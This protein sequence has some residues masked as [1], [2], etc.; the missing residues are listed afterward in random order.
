MKQ[1][2]IGY[3]LTYIIE[4]DDFNP[5]DLTGASATFIMG[6][7]NKL[8]INSP[9][10]I[11]DPVNGVVEYEFTS[12]NALVSGNFLGE[13]RVTFQDGDEIIYPRNG[14][15]TVNI[16]Q[17]ID[18]NMPN[19]ML[20]AI[21]ER[22][23]EFSEKLDS[24]LMQAGNLTMTSMNE[25]AWEAEE[26]QLT[27][28]IPS[29]DYDPSTK[30]FQVYVDNIPVDPKLINRNTDG[31]FTLDIDP[32][33]IEQGMGVIA[34]WTQP[35]GAYSQ[36]Y[37]YAQN[38]AEWEATEGQLV[39]TMPEGVTYDPDGKSLEV[40]IGG[41]VIAASDV[42]KDSDSQ[43]TL[44][45]D[46][47][48][49]PGGVKVLARWVEPYAPVVSGHKKV[50]EKGG[51][52][53]IDIAKLKNYEELVASPLADI[54]Y[55]ITGLVENTDITSQLNAVLSTRKGKIKIPKGTYLITS[56]VVVYSDTTLIGDGINRTILKIKDF[57]SAG[58]VATHGVLITEN[59]GNNIAIENLTVDGNRLNQSWEIVGS[60][61]Y[62][63]TVRSN[64]TV[65][66]NVECKNV[67]DNGC[68]VPVNAK[69]V[70]FDSVFSHGNGKKG[71]HS[72]DVE[73]IQIINGFYYDN[74]TDCGIGMHQGMKKAIITNNHCYNNGNYGIMLGDSVGTPSYE[75]IISDNI[76]YGNATTDIF[77]SGK[78][79]TENSLQKNTIVSNNICRDKGIILT[80]A[81][82]VSIINN[83]LINATILI[84]T[85]FN[86]D[87]KQNSII[88]NPSLAKNTAIK[89]EG[90][91]LTSTILTLGNHITIE[92]NTID[93]TG[94]TVSYAIEGSGHDG[95]K[96]IDNKV[97]GS[98]T[99][100]QVRLWDKYA[101]SFIKH[102]GS[103]RV[104]ADYY[105]DGF[106]NYTLDTVCTT[107]LRPKKTRK[108][109]R[110]FDST[111]G[112]PIWCKTSSVLDASGNVT[113]AAVWVDATGA[114]V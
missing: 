27:Y 94:L 109:E 95:V 99:S 89:V 37:H 93:C 55:L 107:A 59:M 30:W 48:D 110:A 63:I 24:I 106:N 75:V 84:Q 77:I 26:G 5:V 102:T 46:S 96:I 44:L 34:R 43:F 4:D 76:C 104:E 100:N 22:Q 41:I 69:N 2:D 33:I 81:K 51:Y 108:G 85:S 12:Q 14:Y 25:Y 73:N 11:T 7:K 86:I 16:Q 21:A 32:L 60:A 91:A 38:E 82:Y 13:F 70:I 87:V 10:I 31:Q 20:D 112:K 74:E 105:F 53:E 114:T 113:T 72:G 62:G 111:L 39:Y 29:D 19:I 45:L 66:R 47:S 98:P 61:N 71:F 56:D 80:A 8:L 15:I 49:V 64:N 103:T 67:T 90:V 1:T 79:D 18:T 58:T 42:Q 35:I 54:T 52:D 68:G 40:S 83:T 65:V 88:P 78:G 3:L 9:A 28:V 50:H 17:N 23:G 101:T 92:N 36:E 6:K 97:I 57:S